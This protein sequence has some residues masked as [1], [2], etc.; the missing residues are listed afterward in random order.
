MLLR[1]LEGGELMGP[2]R[3]MF[4]YNKVEPPKSFGDLPRYLGAVIGG[5]F[6]RYTYIFRL[7][8]ESGPWITFVLFFVALCNG[9]IPVISAYISRGI[10]NEFQNIIVGGRIDTS[11][12]GFLA[13]PIIFLFI[14]F[15]IC[16]IFSRLIGDLNNAV[17]RLS[18]ELVVKHVKC[19]IMEKAKG[20]DLSAFDLPAFYEKLENANREAGMRPIQ[21]L[22]HTFA[23]ISSLLVLLF[24][25]GILSAQ[26]PVIAII[27]VLVSLPTTI[28][29][30]VF[31]RKNF[32]YIRRRS[33][34]RRKMNYYSDL[35][36]NKDMVKEIKMLGLSNTFIGAYKSIFTKYF[37]G[38]KKLIWTENAI[39]L[40]TSIIASGASCLFY[41]VIGFGVFTGEYQIGDYSFYTEA[42]TSISSS[43]SSLIAYSAVIYEGTLFVDNLMSFLSEKPQIVSPKEPV[44]VRYGQPH[45]I[46]FKNVSFAYPGSDRKVLD[47]VSVKLDPGETAVLVGLN[48]AGK[49]TFIK[50]LTRL[51]D[52][53]EGEIFLDGHDLREYDTQ[54]LY[55]LFGIIFQDFG[56]YAV[57][58]AEN[59]SYGNVDAESDP[60]RI[61]AAARRSNIDE[62]IEKLPQG[63][64]TKLMKYFDHDA[65]ELSIGQWQKLA[66]A[67]AFYSDADILILDEPTASLD[68]IAEQ[69]IFNQFDQLR[70]DK[71]SLF[72]SHRL[73][74]AT[75]ASKIIV[76]ECGKVVEEGTHKELM[77]QKGKYHELF[78]TQ[79]ERYI[80]K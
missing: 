54:E 19:K 55:K 62:Y 39:T 78:T 35:M 70:H 40:V 30:F 18:G 16:K 50:L 76:L 10:L 51:Y 15:F 44:R 36:V 12:D 31:R 20:L 72:V 59:I 27:M 47:G 49:T 74:S 79:A 80:E 5:F 58:V 48:G 67:R 21:I 42:L 69:E 77:E 73:S 53:T 11:L 65:T 25:I 3:P 9:F 26:F 34:D 13:S 14:F 56:K 68:A 22:S 45:T 75:I 37:G 28:V 71:T 52:P 32:N 43:L 4:E 29:N 1:D 61:K 23:V 63:Y 8:W 60:E 66:V 41:I 6:K 7:V 2:G 38:L 46:E 57:S 24:Y 17:T 64:D 33:V